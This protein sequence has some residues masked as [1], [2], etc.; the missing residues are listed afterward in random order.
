MVRLHLRLL[1]PH[2][3]RAGALLRAGAQLAALVHALR[4]RLDAVLAVAHEAGGVAQLRLQRRVD[5]RQRQPR[6]VAGPQAVLGQRGRDV[7]VCEEA[8]RTGEI[9]YKR[10]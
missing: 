2:Q 3:G 5:V 1:Q 8:Q 7:E 6:H 4:H 10:V 9:V